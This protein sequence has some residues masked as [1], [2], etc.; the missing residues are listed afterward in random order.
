M[1]RALVKQDTKFELWRVYFFL[2]STSDPV[3]IK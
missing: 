3:F 2:G 1:F